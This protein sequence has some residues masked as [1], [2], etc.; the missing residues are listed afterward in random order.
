MKNTYYKNHANEDKLNRRKLWP[1]I[2]VQ[3][4]SIKKGRTA[5]SNSAKI[6][7]VLTVPFF[8]TIVVKQV[9]LFPYCGWHCVVQFRM[10]IPLL[11]ELSF[12][13]N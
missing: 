13:H 7:H 2:F 5:N 8:N 12:H 1:V 6:I 11:A 4:C 10:P 3:F 9:K